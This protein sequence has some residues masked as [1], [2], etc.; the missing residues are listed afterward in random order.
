[1]SQKLIPLL[2]CIL[3]Y[4]NVILAQE[5]PVEEVKKHFVHVDIK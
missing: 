4:T 5:N 2:A 3:L 1:M